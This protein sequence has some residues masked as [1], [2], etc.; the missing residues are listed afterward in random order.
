MSR[1][2]YILLAAVVSFIYGIGFLNGYLFGLR[3]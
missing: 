3:P 1:M 2:H